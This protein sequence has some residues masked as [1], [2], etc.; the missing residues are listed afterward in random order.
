MKSERLKAEGKRDSVHYGVLEYVE[1]DE[2]LTWDVDYIEYADM[3]D[4]DIY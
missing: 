1:R 3:Y 2:L 4:V